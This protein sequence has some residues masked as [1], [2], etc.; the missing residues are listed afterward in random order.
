LAEYVRDQVVASS[1]GSN[2]PAFIVSQL[3]A[4][5]GE[6]ATKENE[7]GFG[8]LPQITGDHSHQQL[9]VD[10]HEGMVKGFFAMGQ[11]PA[12][13]GQNA[14]YQRQALAKLDWLVVHDLYETETASFWKDSPEVKSGKL[15]TPEIPTEVFFLPTAGAAEADG[16]LTNTQ[17]LI[18]F[19]E[20]AADPPGDAR[21]DV[22]FTVHLGLRLKELYKTSRLPRDAGIKALTW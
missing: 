13:G 12:V 17:R 21:S 18:Q 1:Y 19:H 14:S 15:R 11:N 20:K 2:F 9:F 5:F 16:S 4:W 22:W 10:M 8:W 3:K 7:F 6:K